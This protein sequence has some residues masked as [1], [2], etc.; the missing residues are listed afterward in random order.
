MTKLA[1][2]AVV[3]MGTAFLSG[4]RAPYGIGVALVTPGG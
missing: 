2:N 3:H 1:G 4:P